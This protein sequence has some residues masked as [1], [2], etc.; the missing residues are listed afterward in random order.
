MIVIKIK[1]RTFLSIEKHLKMYANGGHFIQY[2]LAMKSRE[3]SV[4]TTNGVDCSLV[5]FIRIFEETETQAGL[6]YVP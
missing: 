6:N 1:T 5:I 4:D 3:V 2:E